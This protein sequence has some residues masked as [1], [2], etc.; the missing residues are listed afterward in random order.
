[1]KAT[2]QNRFLH[3]LLKFSFWASPLATEKALINQPWEADVHLI[4]ITSTAE[5]TGEPTP[6]GIHRDGGDYGFVFLMNRQ[7]ATGAVST[8]YDNDRNPIEHHTLTNPMDSMLFWDPYVLHSVSRMYPE[9]REKPAV[10]DALLFGFYSK[11]ELKRPM[12]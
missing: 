8:V 7:N 10:R 11:P 9:N 3:E 6:E 5:K 4:R 12:E 1:L 2:V